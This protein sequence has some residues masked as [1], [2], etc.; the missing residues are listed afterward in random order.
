MQI[1]I[2]QQ[3]RLTTITA[4][5]YSNA[6]KVG[7]VIFADTLPEFPDTAEDG[8]AYIVDL[9]NKSAEE[10]EILR[11]SVCKTTTNILEIHYQCIINISQVMYSYSAVG[12]EKKSSSSILNDVRVERV[13]MNCTGV[14]CCEHL[15]PE[16]KDAHHLS[17]TPEVLNTIREV[18]VT[19]EADSRQ[20]DAN[21]Y[22]NILPI[23]S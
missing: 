16:I 11:G 15:A 7:K 6:V 2:A 5:N 17:I 4:A 21:R 23:Y 12:T 19:N 1:E 13:N 14:Q 18:R 20:K 9:S 8:V 10:I 3:S 22:E